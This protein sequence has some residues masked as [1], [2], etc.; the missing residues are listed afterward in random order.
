LRPARSLTGKMLLQNSGFFGNTVNALDHTSCDTPGECDCTPT[1]FALQTGNVTDES[2]NP[3]DATSTCDPT[4]T[5]CLPTSAA[6][7]LGVKPASCTSID[8]SFVNTYA[9]AFAPG[10]GDGWATGAWVDLDV[11]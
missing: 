2:C 6:A 5:L 11:D 8:T 4:A 9:G 3:I 7:C 10:A 1:E